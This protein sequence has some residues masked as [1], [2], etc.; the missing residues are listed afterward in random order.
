MA[1]PLRLEFPGAVYHVTARGNE[2]R[3]IFTDDED[4]L[5]YLARL[6]HYRTK[7]GFRLLAYCL[8]SNHLHLAIRRGPAPLSRVM[9]GLHSSY[10][11][12]FNRRHR[13][14]GHLFQGRYKA[15]LVQEDRYLQALVRYI[16]LN[17]VRARMVERPCDY[18]WSSERFYRRGGAPP[19][20]DIDEALPSFGP[21]RRSALRRY[22]QLTDGTIDP[23]SEYE[24]LPAL[25]QVVKGNELFALTRL[26]EA[27]QLDPPLRGLSEAGVIAAVSRLTH[28][29]VADLVGPCKGGAIAAARCMAAFVAVRYAGIS[30]RRMARRFHRDDSSLARP[31]HRLEA[32]LQQDPELRRQV[33]DVVTLLRNTTFSPSATRPETSN[34]D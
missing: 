27:G 32:R 13:R 16:H 17:P 20:L 26:G 18:R 30:R 23:S 7:F 3:L 29:P 33:E 10:T 1:R 11:Q 22:L 34:Q 5:D 12:S 15:F 2:R 4:R 25:D 24:N 6:D 14:V 9:A 28:I 31:V 19:W 8:M 21:T